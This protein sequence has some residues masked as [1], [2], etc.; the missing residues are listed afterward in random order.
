MSWQ[1][2]QQGA[3]SALTVP[4]RSASRDERGDESGKG[5]DPQLSQGQAHP[6]AQLGPKEWRE[7]F[8]VSAWAREWNNQIAVTQTYFGHWV[9]NGFCR[10]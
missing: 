3:K 6:E 10:S 5:G 8:R 4:G 9:K 7:V 1:H 2:A